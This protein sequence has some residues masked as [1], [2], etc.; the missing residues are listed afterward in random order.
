MISQ[1]EIQDSALSQISLAL[2]QHEPPTGILP[3]LTPWLTPTQIQEQLISHIND[4]LNLSAGY[5]E[6]VWRSIIRYIDASSA[7]NDGSEKPEPCE[8][9][10]ELYAECMCANMMKMAQNSRAALPTA[11]AGVDTLVQ[12]TSTPSSTF[13]SG[14]P[15]IQ[16]NEQRNVFAQGGC[17]GHRTWEAGIALADF[18]LE[19]VEVRADSSCSK[20]SSTMILRPGQFRHIIELGA[21]TGLV[22]LVATINL[23]PKKITLTDGDAGVI[24]ALDKTIILNEPLLAASAREIQKLH[25]S[26]PRPE[27]VTRTLWW[28]QDKIDENDATGL[29]DLILAADVTYDPTIIEP[30]IKCIDYVFNLVQTRAGGSGPHVLVSAT[31]RSVITLARFKTL[32]VE[33]GFTYNVV[34]SYQ[35][36]ILSNFF[37][38]N[39]SMSPKIIIFELTKDTTQV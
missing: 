12:Y 38:F 8:L 23:Q 22:G 34:R 30:L 16:V 20:S 18:L 10:V 9:L 6:S 13:D 2:R 24:A 25:P 19:S 28:N 4:K 36:P 1:Y 33:N 14:L 39:A 15:P 37:Y 35:A 7:P 26:L 29:P 11:D 21:G 3:L 17:T 27:I 31:E 32:C 5:K